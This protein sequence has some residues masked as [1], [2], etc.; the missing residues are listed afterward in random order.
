VADREAGG[1]A[2]GDE[3]EPR[4]VDAEA[5]EGAQVVEAEV[6]ADAAD[7]AGVALEEGGR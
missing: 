1:Q 3:P 6:P 7:E 5:L 4:E 2:A